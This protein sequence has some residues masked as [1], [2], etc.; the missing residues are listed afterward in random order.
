MFPSDV[1]S[2]CDTCTKPAVKTVADM[3]LCPKCH[4]IYDWTV[5]ELDQVGA[6]LDQAACQGLWKQLL[7]SAAKARLGPASLEWLKVYADWRGLK[8]ETRPTTIAPWGGNGPDFAVGTRIQA[9][10]IA[11]E[12]WHYAQRSGDGWRWVEDWT[13]VAD[14]A[15]HWAPLPPV[16]DSADASPWLQASEWRPGEN[17]PDDE[18]LCLIWANPKASDDVPVLARFTTLRQRRAGWR[19][20]EDGRIH[21]RRP[22]YFAPA[23]SWGQVAPEAGREAPCRG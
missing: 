3:R 7:G 16:P 15:S 11:A 21:R 2:T 8:V 19:L 14:Q 17:D 6:T 10:S 13:L 5:Y 20:V 23:P 1:A 18:R 12:S 9:W 22:I 4:F